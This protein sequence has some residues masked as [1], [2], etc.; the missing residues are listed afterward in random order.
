MLWENS[1]GFDGIPLNVYCARLECLVC[2]VLRA[3]SSILYC[4]VRSLYFYPAVPVRRDAEGLQKGIEI[5]Q[6]EWVL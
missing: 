1:K 5:L 6:I 3:L 4:I 2:F